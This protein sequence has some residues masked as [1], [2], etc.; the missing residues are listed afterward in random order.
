MN[1][2]DELKWIVPLVVLCVLVFANSLSGGFVYDDVRQILRNTLIQDTSMVW[3]ALT[4]DV[5]AFKGDG[6]VAASNYWRPTFTAWHILNFR[7]FG[8][9]PFGWHVA[10]VLLHT[11]VCVMA[12]ALLRRWAFSAIISFAIVLLFAVH[13]I[14]VESVAWISG[15][16]DLLFS[17]TFLGSL[18]FAGNYAKTRSS[19]DLALTILLYALALGAKEIGVLCLP[20]YYFVLSDVETTKKKPADLNT[21]LLV[22]AST[23]V[24]YFLA[25][26]AVLGAVSRPPENAVSFGEAI[27]SIPLMFAFYLRQIFFPYWI[28]ANY[29]L[30]AVSQI[31]VANFP[32]PLLISAA[33]IAAIIYLAKNTDKGKLAAALFILPLVTAMNATAFIPDQMVHD[34][35]LYLPLL[36]L[37]MLIVP[38]A[39]KFLSERYVVIGA[40]VVSV[41]L[42]VQTFTYNTAWASD[43]S[44]WSWTSKIDDSAFTSL[45]YGSEL[46]EKNRPEEAIRYFT[47]SINKAPS[48]R[49]YLGRARAYTKKK[50][51]AD[52]EKDL[53]AS[54]ALG[55]EHTEAYALYQTYEALGIVYSEQKN[56]EAAINNFREARSRLPMYAAAITTNLAI[57][58]YQAARKGEALRELEGAREQSRR[59]LL[60]ESKAVFLRLGMLYAENGMKE[61]ARTAAQEYLLLTSSLT[62]KGTMDGRTQ[63]AA[64]LTAINKP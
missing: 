41:L 42:C 63:A 31:G 28:G 38:F 7:L 22:L 46:T 60:P 33:A 54:L 37:L 27:L 57:V 16:P 13:P 20:I 59:E 14:H 2:R 62:D 44:L 18:W 32:I 34:R 25:R 64:L 30:E 35:Y 56:Y 26:L 21:P 61:D 3:K 6:T 10:N 47:A 39:A 52:A 49:A 55:P 9:N 43:L 48:A 19:T 17:I 24:L 40:A 15:S 5:W 11:G 53:K 50:Q 45:Q 29:P 1:F 51:Y 58:L 23:A 12:Y 36:G 8:T 4:S